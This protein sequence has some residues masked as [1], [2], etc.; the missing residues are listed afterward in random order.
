MK[1]LSLGT[2][3]ALITV[4][5][6]VV[7]VIVLLATAYNELL[8]DFERVL[9]QK[10][11]VETQ[12]SAD[13]VNRSLEARLV[14][15][16][17]FST[18]LT[19]GD[20]LV[21]RQQINSL[22]GRQTTLNDYFPEGLTIMDENA[23]AIAEN[24]FVPGRIGTSYADRSHFKRALTERKPVISSPII[25]RRTGLPLLSF[26]A[27]IESDDGD[28]LGFAGGIINLK[29]SQ[30]IPS[31]DNQNQQALFKVLD[32]ERFIQVDSLA[33][34]APMPELPA[35]GENLII[36]AALSGVTS[37]V[38]TDRDGQRWIYATEHLSRIGWM[39]LRAFPYELATEPA[40]ASFQKFLAISVFATLF[41]AVA[42]L[43]LTRA[44]TRPLQLMS[45]K[46]R[47]MSGDGAVSSRVSESG[48][49]EVRNLAVAFNT[50]MEEREGLDRLKDEFVSTVSHELRTPLTSVNG[51]L[52]LL[53]SGAA[54]ELPPKANAM[55]D[56]AYRNSEQLQ[57]LISDLLDFNKSVAGQMPVFPET[58][59]LQKAIRQACEGIESMAN[60]YRVHLEQNLSKDQTVIADPARLRQILDNFI[61]NAIKFSPAGGTLKIWSSPAPHN[62]VRITVADEGDGVPAT[63]VD[64][65]FQRFAQAESGTDRA[66]AGT[67]LGLAIT[68]E[69]ARLMGGEVG[70]YHENGAH[71]WVELP[72]PKSRSE[73]FGDNH[74]NA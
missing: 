42:A 19:D 8:G 29:E 33:S 59:N 46:I 58:V 67:G 71:F 66:R 38:V 9:T 6:S 62:Q 40:W 24:I 17:A 45:E 51:S 36:D 4:L 53:R 50:L 73:T 18:T 3:I 39:F 63:F 5:T 12:S 7:T 47:A 61:S 16:Q 23:V 44:T 15:L 54:G 74:E 1:S 37:G 60:H 52:K 14:A 41:L 2:R 26:V 49:S 25:G 20:S 28:L 70:Y 34:N 11:L 13:Q 68:R 22:L 48:P 31:S 56:V 57:H 30:L 72:A 27:P 65:L 69:L 35:P 21:S 10:Q 55:V 43:A 32:T 64:R